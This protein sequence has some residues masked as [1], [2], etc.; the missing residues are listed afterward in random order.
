MKFKF[1]L[2]TLFVSFLLFMLLP[3]GMACFQV[4][5][6]KASYFPKE[7]FQAE[8]TGSFARKIDDSNIFLYRNKTELLVPFSIEQLAT[9]KYFVYFDLPESYGIHSFAV[10]DVWCIENET[11]M[12]KDVTQSFTIKK[13]IYLA[14]SSLANKVGDWQNLTAEEN[15]LV[16]LALAYDNRIAAAGKTALLGKRNEGE[17]CWPL[18]CTVKETALASIAILPDERAK[19]WFLLSQNS[20]SLGLW[21]LIVNSTKDATCRLKIN[22]EEKDINVIAGITPIDINLPDEKEIILTLNCTD[23]SAKVTRTY[24]GMVNE[25]PF[26]KEGNLLK[27]T[28]SNEKCWGSIY[29]SS[30]NAEATAYALWALKELGIEDS[31]AV[32]WLLKNAKTTKEKA[33]A[34]FFTKDSAIENWLLNNQAREGYWKVRELALSDTPD[35][36]STLIASFALGENVAVE[37]A[38]SWLLEQYSSANMFGSIQ[39][40]AFTLYKIF[41]YDKIEPILAVSPAVIKAKAN[42]DFSIILKNKGILSID[43]L[44]ST[45]DDIKNLTLASGSTSKV[46]FSISSTSQ[47]TAFSTL[48]ISYNSVVSEEKKL[49]KIP[50]M[51]FP[52]KIEIEKEVNKTAI[53]EKALIE[54]RFAFV[55]EKIEKTLKAEEKTTVEASI[56]NPSAKVVE[57]IEISYSYDLIPVVEKIEPYEIEE[58]LPGETKKI[59]I[60]LNAAEAFG[61]YSG[62]IEAQSEGFSVSLPIAL[63]VQTEL[64]IEEKTCIELGGIKCGED[65]ECEGNVTIASDTAS[66][67]LGVCKEKEE[68]EKPPVSKKKLI[69]ILLLVIAIIAVA[70]FL[71]LRLRPKPKKEEIEEILG[72][73]EEKYK[74]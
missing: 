5:I 46:T 69:G 53:E 63:E 51:I 17:D 23:V 68:K 9:N 13:P 37:K 73:I 31:V 47:T 14:Y 38:K 34:Y 33:F 16:L 54:P 71:L 8:I 41:P 26:A 60:T 58:L 18:T 55:E 27:T 48:E 40:T 66:C 7:T 59:Y 1:V 32:D 35:I 20:V 28:L 15:A 29:R 61:S 67:C 4:E 65:E 44:A 36:E 11:L 70:I 74:R 21:N 43:I 42:A 49:Y 64:V 19:N 12:S 52:A 24:V 6:A 30:C 56:K 62:L 10:K 25:F 45:E 57:N 22:N 50:L 2:V 39:Q 3:L 72:K